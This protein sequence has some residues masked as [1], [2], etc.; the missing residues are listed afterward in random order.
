M[1]HYK[2][3]THFRCNSEAIKIPFMYGTRRGKSGRCWIAFSRRIQTP[4]W[5]VNFSLKAVCTVISNYRLVKT[6]I[7]IKSFSNRV[8]YYEINISRS[9]YSGFS[10]AIYCS[11][12]TLCNAD[13]DEPDCQQCGVELQMSIRFPVDNYVTIQSTDTCYVSIDSV[14]RHN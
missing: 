4:G 6:L 12:I 11:N 9:K 1:R 5:L 8:N 7:R 13:M 3:C 10:S 2:R 14:R